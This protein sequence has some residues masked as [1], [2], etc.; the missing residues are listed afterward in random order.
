MQAAKVTTL[1]EQGNRREAMQTASGVSV[2]LH[3]RL[4]D[5]DGL[6]CGMRDAGTV[7]NEIG[8]HPVEL[9]RLNGPVVRICTP[10]HRQG[11]TPLP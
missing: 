6:V 11:R 8:I 4:F 5:D 7:P 2:H 9:I 10:Q 1:N 3:A